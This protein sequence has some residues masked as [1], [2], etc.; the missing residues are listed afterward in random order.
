MN[1]YEIQTISSIYDE[2]KEICDDDGWSFYCDFYT[3]VLPI[4]LIY[5]DPFLSWLYNKYEFRLGALKMEPNTFYKWHMEGIR[6]CAINMMASDNSHSHCLF[7]GKKQNESS[8]YVDELSYKH[9]TYYLLN[10]QK[11]HCVLNLNTTRY[12][13]TTEFVKHK[14]ELNYLEVEDFIKNNWNSNT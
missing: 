7:A 1:F 11:Y 3:K 13:M 4:E 14:N 2:V 9:K 8:Y 5:K 12:I 6:G 10:N